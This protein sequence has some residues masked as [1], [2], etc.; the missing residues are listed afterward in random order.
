MLIYYVYVCGV[1]LRLNFTMHFFAMTIM[2]RSITG[3]LHTFDEA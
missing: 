2:R 3:A 1:N